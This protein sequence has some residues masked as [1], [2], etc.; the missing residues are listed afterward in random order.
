MDQNV[1]PMKDFWLSCGH[2]LLD[3]DAGGGLVVTDEFLKA[4]LA[5][6][7]LALPPEACVVERTLHAALLAEPRRPVGPDEIA[8][9]ADPDARENW[10]V[11]IALRD[12]LIAH[13]TIEAVYLDLV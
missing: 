9:I 8:A 13:R 4:Y 11:I 1:P 7:E 2:H 5:R 3:R 10:S 6:P 12:R